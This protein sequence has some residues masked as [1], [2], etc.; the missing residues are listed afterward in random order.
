MASHAAPHT[1][2]SMAGANGGHERT[3]GGGPGGGGGGGC[4]PCFGEQDSPGRDGHRERPATQSPAPAEKQRCPSGENACAEE[5]HEP[6]KLSPQP[7]EPPPPATAPIC[8]PGADARPGELP[9]STQCHGEGMAL[10]PEEV[11]MHDFEEVSL[12]DFS[13]EEECKVRASGQAVV[14]DKGA[15]VMHEIPQLKFNG[16]ALRMQEERPTTTPRDGTSHTE[17][18]GWVQALDGTWV[19]CSTIEL[20]LQQGV[21][22]MS[23]CIV[24]THWTSSDIA[25]LITL[26][27]AAG[28]P[29]L[30]LDQEGLDLANRSGSEASTVM[31]ARSC[32]LFRR[33]LAQAL[34]R[35]NVQLLVLGVQVKRFQILREDFTFANGMLF[36]DGSLNRQ[37]ILDRYGHLVDDMFQHETHH[38]HKWMQPERILAEVESGHRAQTTQQGLNG[39]SQHQSHDRTSNPSISGYQQYNVGSESG[40]ST[41]RSHTH[42]PSQHGNSSRSSR[43]PSPRA[44]SREASPRYGARDASPRLRKSQ[45]QRLPESVRALTMDGTVGTAS[46]RDRGRYSP[47]FA[48]AQAS[49]RPFDAS[50][51][52]TSIIPVGRGPLG[53]PV[54]GANFDGLARTCTVGNAAGR[55]PRPHGAPAGGRQGVQGTPRGQNQKRPTTPEPAYHTSAHRD[56]EQV[57]PQTFAGEWAF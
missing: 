49:V 27:S 35:V 8:K 44:Y 6:R 19:D 55:P 22:A 17:A 32:A 15:V 52:T 28:S 53:L 43:E 51:A 39:N 14:I 4:C 36:G 20:V 42:R 9:S 33:G 54:G 48:A 13:G 1:Q 16:A 38:P 34:E 41:P 5:K 50:A 2:N 45:Q 23:Q 56:T 18:A 26:R 12:Q 24:V 3:V 7:E 30:A 46:A 21:K 47:T 25:C 40:T 10:E 37:G 11:D 29:G 57:V 31:S